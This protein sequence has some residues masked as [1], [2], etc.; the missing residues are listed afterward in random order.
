MSLLGKIEKII[1][2]VL[3]DGSVEKGDDFERY[4]VDM[5]DERYFSVV[6]WTSDISRKHDRFVES[7]TNCSVYHLKK[8]N[9]LHSIQVFLKSLK[10]ILKR[11][12]SGKLVN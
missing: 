9:T 4:V 7:D 6:E 5:F 11:I 2:V 10:G 3:E 1:D 12:S 8:Q